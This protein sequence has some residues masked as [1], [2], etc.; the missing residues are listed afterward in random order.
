MER[1]TLPTDVLFVGAGPAN[2]TA[3]YVL[4]KKL[5]AAGKAGEVQIMVIEKGKSVGDHI[6]SGAVM[7]PRAMNEAWGRDWRAR[8][9]PVEADVVDEQVYKFTATDAKP[10]PFIPPTL[11]NHGNVIV[12]LSNVVVWMKEQV[13]ALG[14]MVAEGYPAADPVLE[15]KRVVGVRLVD[16]GREADGREGPSF[17]P[18][19][20]IR[21]KVTVIGE[22]TRGSVTKKLVDALGLHGPNPQVYGTGVKELWDIPAGRVKKGTVWHSAGWP[23]PSS[24]YGGSWIYAQSDTRVSIGFVT[25]LDG[26]DPGCDPYETMQTWKTHPF[27]KRILAGG[28]LVKGGTKTVPEGG[29]WSRPKSHGDG[30]LIVGDAGSLLNIARLKGIHSAIKSGQLAAET[31]FDA[32]QSGG[33]CDEAALAAYEDRLRASWLADELRRVRNWRQAFQKGFTLGSLHAGLMWALGGKIF[34]DRLPIHGDAAA[35]RKGS[36]SA[37]RAY[38]PDGALTFD[39]LTGVYQA[40][41]IHDE[42]QPSHLIVTDPAICGT[43]CKTEYGN[44]CERFCPASVYEMIDATGGGRALRINFSNCVHCKTCDVL[45]PYGVITWTVPQDAGGPKYLGL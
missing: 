26:G 11:K 2:L 42:H 41:S 6:L 32:L 29:W 19:T 39:K 8:G 17:T 13:E 14:V 10:L 30:F 31:I 1:E 12:A 16:Q 40:G 45:D 4:A 35:M 20:E 24:T 18:G 43:K 3:A 7:D 37:G 21:A 38:K 34:A 15:G 23:L 9:C 44:P 33:A 25:A 28:T 22:G 5:E 36:A 27:V